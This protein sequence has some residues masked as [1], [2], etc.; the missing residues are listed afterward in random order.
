M[1]IAF[2]IREFYPEHTGGQ[3][4]YGYLLLKNLI[5]FNNKIS[6]FYPGTLKTSKGKLRIFSFRQIRFPILQFFYKIFSYLLLFLRHFRNNGIQLVHAN[7]AISEGFAAYL[8]KKFFHIPIFITLHGGGIYKFSKKLP[9][10]VK[11][12]LNSSDG[13]ISINSFLKNL[14]VNFTKRQIE[15]IP[16]FIDSVRFRKKISNKFKNLKENMV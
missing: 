8:I 16:N 1:N 10:I 6:L 13:I 12:V 3:G 7:G 14:A 2:F 11:L 5:R 4:L 9:F 15:I